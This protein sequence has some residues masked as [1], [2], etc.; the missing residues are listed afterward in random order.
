MWPYTVMVP[1]LCRIRTQSPNPLAGPE[2]MT[3]PSIT[4][5]T[6]VPMSLA[7]SRP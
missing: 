4:D 1:S 7:M 2:S 3:L 6:G 5:T